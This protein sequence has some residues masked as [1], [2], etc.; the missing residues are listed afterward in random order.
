VLT[1]L[2]KKILPENYSCKIY[3]VNNMKTLETL[4]KEIA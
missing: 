3:N 1:G 2:L 4:L